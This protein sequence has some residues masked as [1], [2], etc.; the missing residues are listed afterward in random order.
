MPPNP[1]PLTLA[2]CR[3]GGGLMDNAFKYIIKNGG[4]DT[5]EDYGYWSSY[6]ATF[7]GCNKRKEHDR[8]VVSID[9]YEVRCAGGGGQQTQGARQDSRVHR[10]L[11]G[12]VCGGGG[13]TGGG[14]GQQGQRGVT[15]RS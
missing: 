10:W 11:R 6:G 9:G 3:C 5:E 13:G 4:L 1:G 15:G 14:G 12:A 2:C 8:T 7:W